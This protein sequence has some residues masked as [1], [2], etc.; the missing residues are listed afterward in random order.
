MCM[1]LPVDCMTLDELKKLR[2]DWKCEL[3]EEQEA[4]NLLSLE[5]SCLALID[6]ATIDDWNAAAEMLREKSVK[7]RRSIVL[8]ETVID[9]VTGRIRQLETAS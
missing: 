5:I 9:G 4:Y 6:V 2:V 1:T 8:L 7:Q 3:H